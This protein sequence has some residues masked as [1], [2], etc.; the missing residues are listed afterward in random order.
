MRHHRHHATDPPA[1]AR[2]PHYAL[3]PCFAVL[4]HVELIAWLYRVEQMDLLIPKS[5]LPKVLES[6]HADTAMR[7]LLAQGWYRSHDRHYELLHHADVVRQ[8]IAAQRKAR[9]TS[10]RTSRKHR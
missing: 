1:L 2:I 8:S 10:K 7:E 4:V 5:R 9:E 3:A 6:E